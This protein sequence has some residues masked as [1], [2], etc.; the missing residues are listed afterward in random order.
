MNN[1]TITIR[2]NVYRGA[3]RYAKE[4]NMSID[5]FVENII[6]DTI[7]LEKAETPKKKF[8]R[9]SYDE[10]SPVVKDLIGHNNASKEVMDDLDGHKAR[11]E[12]LEK[13]HGA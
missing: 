6:I 13:K 8:R 1:G 9:K 2:G 7:G 4:H 3:Q 12:Y 10:L 5:T 11:M